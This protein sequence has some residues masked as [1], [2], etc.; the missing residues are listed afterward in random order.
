MIYSLRL[1]QHQGK[2]GMMTAKT[3][4]PIDR[5]IASVCTHFEIDT[6]SLFEKGSA[7]H[8]AHPRQ[9]AMHLARRLC[10]L[11]DRAIAT[12]FG[13][14]HRGTVL[15]ASSAVEE[16]MKKDPIT[17]LTVLLLSGHLKETNTN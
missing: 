6:D 15:Y 11:S 5:V 2:E 12:R 9:V 16:R 4:V 1:E 14:Y 13:G 10:R 7:R 17:K 8:I 3:G